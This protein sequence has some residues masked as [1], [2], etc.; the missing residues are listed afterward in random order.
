[1]IKQLPLSFQEFGKTDVRSQFAG[2]CYQYQNEKLRILLITSRRTRRWIV[3]KGWL[4]NNHTP[5][6]S[7]AREAWEEAGVIG[8]AIETCVGLFAYRKTI[9]EDDSLPCVAMIYPVKVNRLAKKYPEA[10]QRK[11]KWVS[12][13]EAARMV[14]EPEL[15]RILRDFD[16]KK[17]R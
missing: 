17:L 3:P 15:A 7:A 5:A 16:P 4:K 8:K 10:G 6:Q 2:L 1:M 11:R 9:S 13:K 12:R 14:D